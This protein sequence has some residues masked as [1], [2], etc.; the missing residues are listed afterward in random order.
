MTQEDE[1]S[2]KDFI[3][4]IQARTGG[5]YTVSFEPAPVTPPTPTTFT[6]PPTPIA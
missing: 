1:Q 4:P 5:I 2:L 6:I 3:T